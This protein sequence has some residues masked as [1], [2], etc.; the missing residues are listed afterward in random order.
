M[1]GNAAGQ[2]R[3]EDRHG[4]E[5]LLD[6][7]QPRLGLSF[8]LKGPRGTHLQQFV[9][10]LPKP[11]GA[12]LSHRLDHLDSG[13]AQ[14]PLSPPDEVRMDKRKEANLRVK[15]SITKTLF[16]LMKEKSLADI[17]ITELVNGAGVARA[18]FYRNY[19]SKEDVLVMLIRDV[20]HE[21]SA[22]IVLEQG[23]FYTYHNVLLSFRY[24]QTYRSYILD[25][26]RSGLTTV[27]LEEL[28]RFHE[29][30][31]GSMPSPSI[32]KY[33]L[34]LYIGALFN[35]AIIWLMEDEK[36]SPEE[37]AHFFLD[38]ASKMLNR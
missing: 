24:F 30:M 5:S 6:L 28:N 27:L 34:Y 29:T 19:C 11:R 38:A 15:Q 21:F 25:L 35:T 23:S 9:R 10:D 36:T 1:A 17:H 20:L 14:E 18:S 8:L 16:A 12:V 32:E 37:M 31:E 7:P 4:G 26:Y 3:I 2:G 22:E 33:Q 13:L